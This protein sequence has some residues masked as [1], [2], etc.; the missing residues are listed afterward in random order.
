MK[1]KY[2]LRG[3]GVGILF[4][5]L[6]LVVLVS[7]RKT[8]LSDE[9]IIQRAEQLGMAKKQESGINMEKLRESGSPSSSPT[10]T[11]APSPT[12]T[13]APSPTPSPTPTTTSSPTPTEAP[14][15]TPTEAPSP[16]PTTPS[17]TP[18]TSADKG[19]DKAV[20]IQITRGMT[21]EQVCA[22]IEAAGLV[23]DAMH[24]NEYF[25]KNGYAAELRVG[26]FQIQM[27]MTYEEIAIA[28]TAVN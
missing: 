17:P 26:S 28:L 4:T 3:L 7:P 11:E 13:E 21:S 5:V 14:S 2:Y 16:T 19:T 9:E 6:V 15:P 18:T 27:G 8:E 20:T 23:T 22:L 10:P 25:I 1:L 12:P 24:L